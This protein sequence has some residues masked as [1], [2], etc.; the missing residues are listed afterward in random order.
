VGLVALSQ[1][2]K[3]FRGDIAI[4]QLERI[5][6]IRRDGKFVIAGVHR[7]GMRC[8]KSS[9]YWDDDRILTFGKFLSETTI[10]SVMAVSVFRGVDIG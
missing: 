8:A 1:Y 9:G 5:Y 10:L 3:S 2:V 7:M 6:E 4:V